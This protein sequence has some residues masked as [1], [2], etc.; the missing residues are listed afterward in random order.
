M[1]SRFVRVWKKSRRKPR[2][3]IISVSHL[4]MS[5]R[6]RLGA[7]V[8]LMS[9]CKCKSIRPYDLITIIRHSDIDVQMNRSYSY[10]LSNAQPCHWFVFYRAHKNNHLFNYHLMMCDVRTKQQSF[11]GKSAMLCRPK[12]NSNSSK[13]SCIHYNDEKNNNNL[14]RNLRIFFAHRVY[15]NRIGL[16]CINRLFIVCAD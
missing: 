4:V 7:K 1:K 6:L 16:A 13:A 15:A 11:N 8:I 10:L 12:F 14:N 9:Y 3:P 5:S 2:V